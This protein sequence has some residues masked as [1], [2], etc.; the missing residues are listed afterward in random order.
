MA[1]SSPVCMSVSQTDQRSAV[2]ASIALSELKAALPCWP[3]AG[4]RVERL[5]SSAKSMYLAYC[6]QAVFIS[7]G[8]A[9]H[10]MR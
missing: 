2:V 4:T 6:D 8:S 7:Y 5:N 1:T 3:P 10:R 9:M